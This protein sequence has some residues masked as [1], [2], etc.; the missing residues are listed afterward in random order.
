MLFFFRKLIEALLL[1]VGIA[2]LLTIG[3]VMFRRRWLAITG[4][5]VLYACSTPLAGRFLLESLEHV[6][7]FRTV[8]SAPNADA[9]VVLSGG[10]VR[11]T[12][13]PGIQW[14]ES[15]N[16]Y[17]A[18]VGLAIAGKAKVIVFSAD[19]PEGHSQADLTREA[20]ISQGLAPERIMIV[21]PALTTDDEAR[22]VSALPK[23]RSILL[24]TSAFHMPRAVL[25]FRAR[26]LT[27]LPFPT[28]QRV[29]GPSEVSLASF[30]PDARALQNS[31][32]AIREYYGLAAYR[33]ILF[34]RP[35]GH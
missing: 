30:I 4:A 3:S 16:R 33:L 9:I 12:A 35:V 32:Q 15:S 8:A 14:G 31:E 28:D 7:E 2:L 10:V 20:A 11:G 13:A 34:L 24:V 21:R 17:F 22:A 29:L 27:V 26:G 18:G 1:P 5:V 23:I 19:R 6:Y 25:Q